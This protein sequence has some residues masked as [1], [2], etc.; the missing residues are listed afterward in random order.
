MTLLTDVVQAEVSGQVTQ[1]VDT[2][3]NEKV[4]PLNEG[5][6]ALLQQQIN[7]LKREIAELERKQRAEGLTAQETR[8][9]TDKRI[10]L[11]GQEAALRAIKEAE[12]A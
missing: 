2:K 1:T 6:K 7:R 3:L 9:L 11:N 10:D 12:K 5:F 8:D 4:R